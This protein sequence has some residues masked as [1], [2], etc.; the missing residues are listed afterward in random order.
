MEE[1]YRLLRALWID[2]E[3][4]RKRAL[5][6]LYLSWWHWAE[7]EFLAGLSDD[8]AALDLWHEIFDHFGGE[9][10]LDAEFLF[11]AAIMA[12]VTPWAFGDEDAW[13]AAADTMMARSLVLRPG[14]FSPEAFLGRGDYGEYFAHQGRRLQLTTGRPQTG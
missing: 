9:A 13:T 12:S 4:D 2:G 5:H 14:G 3:R 8:P 10:S 6:L 11:V 1:T 7:P